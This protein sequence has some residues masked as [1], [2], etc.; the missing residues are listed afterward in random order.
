MKRKKKVAKVDHCA[1]DPQFEAMIWDYTG[2]PD[3]MGGSVGELVLWRKVIIQAL[4]DFCSIAT[5][6][7]GKFN[8]NAAARWFLQSTKHFAIV[9]ELADA[10]SEKLRHLIKQAYDNPETIL[11]E[12]RSR[13]TRH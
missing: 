9:C 6:P 10:D 3:V 5:S 8:Q 13:M 11:V 4:F 7:A 12:L 1:V 2:N